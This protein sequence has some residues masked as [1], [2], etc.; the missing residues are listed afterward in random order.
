MKK[1]KCSNEIQFLYHYF[2]GDLKNKSI[3]FFPVPG[4]NFQN[5]QD[6]NKKQY[7]GMLNDSDERLE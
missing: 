6:R 3:T 1:K 4:K 2:I 7:N 5:M